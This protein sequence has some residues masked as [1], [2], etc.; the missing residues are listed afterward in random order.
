MCLF[1]VVLL[2]SGLLLEK[3]DWPFKNWPCFCVVFFFFCFFLKKNIYLSI[4]LSIYLYIYSFN[5][6][7]YVFW[8]KSDTEFTK[9]NNEASSH[10]FCELIAFA[11]IFHFVVEVLL[12]A[13]RNRRSVR[14]GSAGRP[15]RLSHSSWALSLYSA[16][17]MLFCKLFETA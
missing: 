9:S 14:D 4:Y 11:G 13:H 3:R 2:K 10:W 8:S 16:I 6:Y 15:P 1:C 7:F 12:Y 5:H 17:T